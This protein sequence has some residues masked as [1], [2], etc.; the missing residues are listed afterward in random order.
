MNQSFVGL[1]SNVDL[2]YKNYVNWE[3]MGGKDLNLGAFKLTNRQMFWLTRAQIYAT[4]DHKIEAQFVNP[5]AK[6]QQKY[7]HVRNKSI[8]KLRED[9]KCGNMT[10]SEEELYQEYLGKYSELLEI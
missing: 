8:P 2:A 5:R 3:A 6:L 10:E 7:F 4:K 1:I 9:F